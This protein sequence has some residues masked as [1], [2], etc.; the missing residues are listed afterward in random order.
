MMLQAPIR[1]AD[2]AADT[3]RHAA[4]ATPHAPMLR[5]YADAPYA[6]ADVAL[7]IAPCRHDDGA[8]LRRRCYMMPMRLLR[9]IA[10]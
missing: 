4:A 3:L 10:P 5:R 8:P 1:Y 7:L 6:A 2:A 9:P